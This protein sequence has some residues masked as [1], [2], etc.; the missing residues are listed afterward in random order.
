MITRTNGSKWG[1]KNT[2]VNFTT[3]IHSIINKATRFIVVCGYNFSP[4]THATSIIPLLIAKKNSGVNVL[5]IAPP[6]MLSWGRTNH[7]TIIQHLSNNGISVL[8]NSYNHSKWILSDYGY[9]YGSL[10]FT[11][12]SMTSRVEVVSY[13][14]K[15]NRSSAPMWMAETANELLSFAI[16]ETRNITSILSTLDLGLANINNLRI[17]NL[18]L[19]RILKYNPS[20]EKI[21]ITLENYE[22]VRMELSSMV[23]HAFYL[24]SFETFNLF[25]TKISSTIQV[26]DRLAFIG[27][28][29][30]LKNSFQ[31]KSELD[32]ELK[33]Y[34]R[35]HRIFTLKI[36]DLISLIEKKGINWIKHEKSINSLNES[37][38]ILEEFDENRQ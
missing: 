29:V 38:K 22:T 26:L 18:I 14:E 9:Y 15:I 31:D 2:G 1:I 7:A 23:D 12:Y 3:E 27:N 19:T 6:D 11:H 37:L 25:W 8:L 35:I 20:I 21:E 16:D 28:S 24:T 30:Y 33:L 17:L 13:C 4:L 32:S 5:F 36:Y 34:N 10:N